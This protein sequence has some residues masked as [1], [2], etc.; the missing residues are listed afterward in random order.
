MEVDYAVLG[1]HEF[2]YGPNEL[3]KRIKESKF[4][5]FGTNVLEKDNETIFEGYISKLFLIK[6]L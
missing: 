2:D 5:W 4:K 6:F 3:K 1:N